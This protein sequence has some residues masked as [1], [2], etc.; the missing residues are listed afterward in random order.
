MTLLP[1]AHHSAVHAILVLMRRDTRDRGCM[2]QAAEA[3][4]SPHWEERRREE[5]RSEEKHEE[6]VEERRACDG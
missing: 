2:S 6:E 5:K 3:A 4:L 1:S